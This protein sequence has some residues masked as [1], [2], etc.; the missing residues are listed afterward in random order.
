[1]H[2]MRSPDPRLDLRGRNHKEV[3]WKGKEKEERER[4][5]MEK[6]EGRER[7]GRD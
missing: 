5:G 3:E 7:N 1:M 2:Q 4:G 6:G